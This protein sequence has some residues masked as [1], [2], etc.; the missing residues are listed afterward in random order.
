MEIN[1]PSLQKEFPLQNNHW[2]FTYRQWGFD[3]KHYI[4]V[5]EYLN[6]NRITSY[7][8]LGAN[9]GG[10]CSILLERIKTL[11]KCYLFEPQNDNFEFMSGI[12]KSDE[13]VI[14]YNFGI[15]YTESEFVELFRCDNNVGGY[16]AI[17]FNENFI[18]SGDKMVVKKL[19]DF[20]FSGIDFIKIDVE[21]SEENIILNSTYLKDIKYIELELHENLLDEKIAIE[22]IEK[23]MT[24]H[25]IVH[26]LSHFPSHVFLEKIA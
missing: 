5:I 10:V 12:F 14:C 22:F 8:D 18:S 21:G 6:K 20:N 25:S 17:K 13:R 2:N 19:E 4:D 3:E 23:N 11:E 16:T 1:K 7:I 9:S 24:S 26:N 15:L